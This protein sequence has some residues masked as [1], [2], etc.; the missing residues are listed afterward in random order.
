MKILMVSSYLPYPLH[1]GGHIR[2]YNILKILG[3]KHEITLVCEKRSHQSEKDIREVEKICHKVITIPRKKQWSFSN[4]LKTGL[5][6]KPFLLTGHYLP[7]MQ[8]EIEKLLKKEKFDLIHV[9]TFYVAQNLPAGRQ[10]L[11]KTKLPIVIAEHNIEYLVYKRYAQKAQFFLR[12]LI[13]LDVFKLKTQEEKVWRSANVVVS[14]SKQDKEIIEPFNKNIYVVPNGVDVDKF[15]IKS[16]A[17]PAGR[18]ESQATKNEK[19]I[20]Y[21]G[22]FKW[23]QNR[24]AVDLIL[25]K[26]WPEINGRWKMLAPRS[27]GEAGKNGKLTL[28]IVG[29]NIPKNLKDIG[30]ENV[31]FDENATDNTS[32]IFKKSDILLAPIRFGGGTSYKILEAMASGVPVVTTMLG[33]AGL[34]AEDKKEVIIV[35][36]ESEMIEGVSNLLKDTD[37]FIKIAQSARVLIEK[38]YS[39]DIITTELDKVYKNLI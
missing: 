6:N 33:A 13:N 29:K 14:V 38:K 17:M 26:I 31:V 4:I 25:R 35:D 27:L 12:P 16:Y 18:Q 8:E 9:E 3:T 15:R 19:T 28:W 20:L 10:G 23:V 36:T 22:D 37:L 5:S 1:S 7:E 24:D 32:E 34:G 2:L 30:G 39:W 11:P 21:I